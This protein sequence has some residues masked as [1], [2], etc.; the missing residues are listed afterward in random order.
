MVFFYNIKKKYNK[1]K[2]KKNVR[3]NIQLFKNNYFKMLQ[4]QY[5]YYLCIIIEPSSELIKKIDFSSIYCKI[6]NLHLFTQ[7]FSIDKTE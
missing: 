2:Y 7:I 1:E 6:K 5:K 4:Q 3:L